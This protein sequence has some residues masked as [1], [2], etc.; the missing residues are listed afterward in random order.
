M[1]NLWLVFKCL[2]LV[3]GCLVMISIIVSIVESIRNSF[4]KRDYEQ[5]LEDIICK[6]VEDAME[7]ASKD[8]EK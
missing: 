6:Y 1:E 2:C 8:E 5:K 4:R 7:E 3:A